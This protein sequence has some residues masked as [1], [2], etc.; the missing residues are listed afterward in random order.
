MRAVTDNNPPLSLRTC[1]LTPVR[2]PQRL[3]LLFF[4]KVV[5]S[6][7]RCLP[8]VVRVCFDNRIDGR[9]VAWSRI[10]TPVLSKNNDSIDAT[11]SCND[12]VTT[13]LWLSGGG[14]CFEKSF[15]SRPSSS[16][17]NVSK[18]ST[19]DRPVPDWRLAVDGCVFV[20]LYHRLNI[21]CM[22]DVWVSL[23]M[24]K[25]PKS[26]K[27]ASSFSIG[28]H[29]SISLFLRKMIEHSS[30]SVVLWFRVQCV[31]CCFF[32]LPNQSIHDIRSCPMVNVND[33]N[34]RWRTERWKFLS[35]FFVPIHSSCV[36]SPVS[37]LFG[38]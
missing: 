22:F 13:E 34:V 28:P 26:V 17:L 19:V 27:F 3:F 29:E 10:E 11:A 14:L 18:M 16:S 9:S 7:G 23:L 30:L 35:Q 2:Q 31:K 20:S 36:P 25:R 4:G 12:Q 6:Y 32:R 24:S 33:R 15:D 38:S 8:I 1:V 5:D 21:D 37:L